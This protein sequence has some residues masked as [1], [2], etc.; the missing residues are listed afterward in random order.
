MI[1]GSE[2]IKMKGDSL[3][4]AEANVNCKPRFPSERERQIQTE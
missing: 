1:A 4:P 3:D 2:T